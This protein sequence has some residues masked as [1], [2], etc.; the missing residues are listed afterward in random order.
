MKRDGY[1]CRSCYSDW[2]QQNPEEVL[3]QKYRRDRL[4][5]DAGALIV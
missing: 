1:R 4:S 5:F 2:Y 3:L